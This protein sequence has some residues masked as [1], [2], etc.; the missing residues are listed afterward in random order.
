MLGSIGT[1]YHRSNV[2]QSLNYPSHL[3]NRW[4]EITRVFRLQHI[5]PIFLTSGQILSIALLD[6]LRSVRYESD[7]S[8][9]LVAKAQPQTARAVSFLAS[10]TRQYFQSRNL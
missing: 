1:R 7:T 4:T 8:R 6:Q 5:P 3:L 9:H 10:I 2:D